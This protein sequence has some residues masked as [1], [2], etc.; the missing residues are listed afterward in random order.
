MRLSKFP[1][2]CPDCGDL[3]TPLVRG[4][5]PQ[6]DTVFFCNRCKNSPAASKPADPEAPP[7]QTPKPLVMSAP[8]ERPR[9]QKCEGCSIQIPYN[10]GPDFAWDTRLCV[11][12]YDKKMKEF[13]YKNSFWGKLFG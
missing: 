13:E 4:E 3:S 8:I 2:Y 6:A 9:T 11:E 5:G 7:P 12:C 10:T 1:F